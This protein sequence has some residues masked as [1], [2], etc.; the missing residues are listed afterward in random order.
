MALSGFCALLRRPSLSDQR[1]CL[2]CLFH[3]GRLFAGDGP[4]RNFPL[5]TVIDQ[6]RPLNVVSQ[7][8]LS[9]ERHFNT[10]HSLELVPHGQFMACVKAEFG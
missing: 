3:S 1:S 6:L 8:W 4:G 10:T 9:G 2:L 5:P 7:K